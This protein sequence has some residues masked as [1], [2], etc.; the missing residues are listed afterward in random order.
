MKPEYM[1]HKLSFYTKVNPK[2]IKI[3][4]QQY[5]NIELEVF[6]YHKYPLGS[7][8]SKNIIV[9]G[10]WSCIG[11]KNIDEEPTLEMGMQMYGAVSK[12]MRMDFYQLL[13]SPPDNLSEQPRAQAPQKLVVAVPM[14]VA[15]RTPHAGF[16][17]RLHSIASPQSAA[18]FTALETARTQVFILTP[19]FNI[20]EMRKA[21]VKALERKI[22]IHIILS[23]GMLD[24]GQRLY[25]I[26]GKFRN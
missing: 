9:D 14:I 23:K 17:L 10:V 26:K 5:P 19:N 7:I 16:T 20:P 8:H 11:S 1:A 4:P 22:T 6:H 12:A 3:D 24:G 25:I 21:V 13:R 2:V 15:G 18:W